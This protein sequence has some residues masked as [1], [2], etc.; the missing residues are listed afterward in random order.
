MLND[1]YVNLDFIVS[2]IM[3]DRNIDDRQYEKILHKVIDGY[4][5][6]NINDIIPNIKTVELVVNSQNTVPF[7]KDYINYVFIGLRFGGRVVP[8]TLN[9]NLAIPTEQECGE[10]VRTSTTITNESLTDVST[11]LDYNTQDV[12]YTQGG[13]FNEAYYRIDEAN[14]QIIFLN[15]RIANYTVVLDYKATGLSESTVVSRDVVPALVNFVHWQLNSFDKTVSE[16]AIERSRLDW[17]RE[18]TKLYALRHSFTVDEY[19]DL[20]YKN[21]YRGTK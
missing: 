5:R 2:S 11:Y 15:Q 20:R 10:W 6:L 12:N 17:V 1:G 14:K 3:I 13:A 16:T 19:L 8:L 9:R 7:P 21:T 18:K 4:Q